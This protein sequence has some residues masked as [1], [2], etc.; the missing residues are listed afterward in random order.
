MIPLRDTIKSEHFPIVNWLI[1]ILNVLVFL[2]ML[3]LDPR[4]TE[5]FVQK[6]AL[7]PAQTHLFSNSSYRF[8]TTMFIHGSWWHIIGNMWILYIFGDNVEDRMG[9]FRYLLFY[10]LTGLLAGFTHYILYSN[11]AVPV[12][13][14]SGAI[15]GV[16]AAYMFMFPGSMILSL[17][18]IFIL[19]LF[20]PIPALIYIGIWFII[21]LFSGT[22]TLFAGQSASGIAFWAHIG[23]FLA[24]WVLYK[25]FLRKKFRKKQVSR[26]GIRR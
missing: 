17:V 16:M 24:G 25:Y 7:V 4:Q 10:L 2:F 22:F 26:Q 1:I 12:V 15:S 21:Q 11:S 20:M 23:G 14:A 5:W 9:S 6:F 13:G 8:F 3:S 18:P 19:P